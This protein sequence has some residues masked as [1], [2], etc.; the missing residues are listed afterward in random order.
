MKHMWQSRVHCVFRSA[1]AQYFRYGWGSYAL[2]KLMN[3]QCDTFTQCALDVSFGLE[4]HN[5][6]EI[7]N[8]IMFDFYLRLPHV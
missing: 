2:C 7:L 6:I 1:V 8:G 5:A 4:R 3:T